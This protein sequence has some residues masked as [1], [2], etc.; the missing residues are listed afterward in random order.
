MTGA[1]RQFGGQAGLEFGCFRLD[2]EQKILWQDG[3]VVPLGPKVVQTLFVLAANAGEVVGKEE[4]IRQVWPDITVEDNNLAH[5]IFVLRKALKE[6]PSGRFSIETVPRRGY[7]FC[8]KPEARPVAVPIAEPSKANIAVP[9]T[10]SPLP[11]KSLR[12][13]LG[14]TAAV[15][16]LIALGAVGLH[17]T[18]VR[19]SD[20]GRQR[21]AVAVLGFANLSQ[22]SDAAWMSPALSEMLSSELG[23]GGKLLTIPDESVARA[24]TELNLENRNGFS[25]ETLRRLRHNLSA[26][27]IVSG[28]YTVLPPKPAGTL[29]A[30][31]DPQVRLDLRVQNATTGETVDTMQRSR[32]AIEPLRFDRARGSASSR[33]LGRGRHRRRRSRAGTPIGI[34][35]P[36]RT[37]VVCRGSGEVARL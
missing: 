34:H 11:E 35:Q 33:R 29:T 15:A 31:T 32:R 3:Q 27:L 4:L 36:R 37:A 16:L 25:L 1:A 9:A 5:N 21:R 18:R 8:E 30:G 7:R 20:K 14:L 17:L 13:W 22:K 23:A 12:R 2:P 26:D 24:R 6:D 19:A 10:L 28:A